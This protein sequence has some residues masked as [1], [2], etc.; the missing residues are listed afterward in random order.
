MKE[1]FRVETP[2]KGGRDDLLSRVTALFLTVV[3]LAFSKFVLND[4]ILDYLNCADLFTR[5]GV[6]DQAWYFYDL[7]VFHRQIL[8]ELRFIIIR[9]YISGRMSIIPSCFFLPFRK[10]FLPLNS[11]VFSWVFEFN[12]IYDVLINS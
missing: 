9:L 7:H 4:S 8:R 10:A 2:R 6:I 3:T 5:Y 12:S 1:V 11:N